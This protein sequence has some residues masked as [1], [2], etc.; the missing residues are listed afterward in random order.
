MNV[1]ETVDDKG[2]PLLINIDQITCVRRRTRTADGGFPTMALRATDHSEVFFSG[3]PSAVI[4]LSV[5]E[6]LRKLDWFS[7]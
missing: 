1:L 3:G 6:L 7:K 2:E 5:P 4:G